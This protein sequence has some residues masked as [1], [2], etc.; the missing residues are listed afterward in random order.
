MTPQ[1]QRR[2]PT[3]AT[4]CPRSSATGARSNAGARRRAWDVPVGPQRGRQRTGSIT[5]CRVATHQKF[6]VSR[7]R[8]LQDVGFPP[9]QHWYESRHGISDRV[10]HHSIDQDIV[11]SHPGTPTT[12]ETSPCSQ[13]NQRTEPPGIVPQWSDGTHRWTTAQALLA[14]RGR[15]PGVCS[16]AAFVVPTVPCG[17]AAVRCGEELLGRLLSKHRSPAMRRRSA[18]RCRDR[19]PAPGPGRCPPPLAQRAIWASTRKVRVA[20]AQPAKGNSEAQLSTNGRM[21]AQRD[22]S[23]ARGR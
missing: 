13:G 8:Q 22:S 23:I 7:C 4:G 10:E 1:D 20:L 2:R 18:R 19:R 17:S 14:C 16:P 3:Q 21:A 12:I 5:R 6:V 11:G 15:P 9:S